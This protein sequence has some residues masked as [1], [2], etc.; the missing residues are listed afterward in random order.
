MG[1]A[2]PAAEAVAPHYGS[3]LDASRLAA[4]GGVGLPSRANYE[5]E[6]G[7][8][9]RNAESSLSVDVLI[10]A[11]SAFFARVLFH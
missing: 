9:Q 11:A 7:L 6:L 1:I 8:R 2:K 4:Q 3:W 5:S 10:A